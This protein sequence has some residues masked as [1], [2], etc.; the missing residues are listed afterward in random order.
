MFDNCKIEKT[1][2]YAVL[3]LNGRVDII[4]AEEVEREVNE[5][6][7]NEVYNL[8]FDMRD[9]IYFSSSGVRMLIAAKN[10]IEELKGKI[11]LSKLSSTAEKIMTTLGLLDKYKLCEDVEKAIEYIKS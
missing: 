4:V 7:S 8:V 5:L 9:V 3:Y 10:R 11:V 1:D 2:D 6:L